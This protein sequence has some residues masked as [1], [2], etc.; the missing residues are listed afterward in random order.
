M[1]L[2]QKSNGIPL[3]NRDDFKISY[4]LNATIYNATKKA[5]L[6]K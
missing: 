2:Q 1:L 3:R 6:N 4:Y 5:H